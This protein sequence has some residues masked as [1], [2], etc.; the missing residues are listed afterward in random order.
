MTSEQPKPGDMLEVGVDGTVSV[1]AFQLPLSAALSARNK[2]Q[3]AAMLGSPQRIN[4]VDAKDF[5]SEA[6]FKIAVD[7]MR[8]MLDEGLARPGSERLLETFPVDIAPDRIGGVPVEV[9]TPKEGLDPERVLIN[10]HGGAF[11]SGATY[12]ARMESIPLAHMGR[13]RVVSVDYR[14]GYEHRFPAASE[15]VAAVYAEL[16]KDY[17]PRQIGIC[18]ASAGGMLTAQATAWIIEHG[19]P[20]PGAIGVFSAGTGGA[21]DGDYFAA[22]GSGKYPPDRIMTSIIE[23]E[24]GY[25]AGARSDDPLVNPNISP[26]AF[27]ARFPPTLLITATRAFDLS[28]ALATH[29]ALCQAGVEASLHVFDGL[30]HSFFYG[31][32]TPEAVD[33]YET[34]IRFFRKHLAK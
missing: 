34:I 1:G 33:A 28:P 2:A 15:D 26:E 31:A 23:A 18:G 29:R 16:L 8:Q 19:L 20:T 10:L 30:G 14:Q 17:A 7:A 5:T 11:Y 32:A 4:L 21:G 9:V 27:R 13:F 6:E 3:L 12:V 22:V 24:V 25:F